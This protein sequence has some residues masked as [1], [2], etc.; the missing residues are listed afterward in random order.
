MCSGKLFYHETVYSHTG[1][2]LAGGAQKYSSVYDS[3][4][5]ADTE[6]LHLTDLCLWERA[7]W[8]HTHSCLATGSLT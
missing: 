2:D 1:T 3:G 7:G 8:G 4:E 6:V 5:G